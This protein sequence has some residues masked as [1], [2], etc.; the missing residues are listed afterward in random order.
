MERWFLTFVRTLDISRCRDG[1]S[2]SERSGDKLELHGVGGVDLL[3]V[4][5]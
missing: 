3:L 2:A 4:S 5:L 1:R